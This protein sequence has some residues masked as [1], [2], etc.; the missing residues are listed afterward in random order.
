MRTHDTAVVETPDCLLAALEL[1]NEAVVIADG[2]LRVSH[3][4]GRAYLEAG[5]R[6]RAR[7]PREL[8]GA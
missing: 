1:A 4:N 5:S 6:R 7:L 2:D 3:F 8:S